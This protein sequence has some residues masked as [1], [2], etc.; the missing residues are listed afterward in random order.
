MRLIQALPGSM[1]PL[2]I[3]FSL[4]E[5]GLISRFDLRLLVACRLASSCEV[6]CLSF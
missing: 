4:V 5:V 1:C 3:D 2:L 6:E